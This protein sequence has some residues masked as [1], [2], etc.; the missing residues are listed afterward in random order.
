[1]DSPGK[2]S[3]DNELQLTRVLE[4]RLDKHRSSRDPSSRPSMSGSP[5]IIGASTVAL[6]A[7]TTPELHPISGCHLNCIPSPL[8]RSSSRSHHI[9]SHGILCRGAAHR[10]NTTCRVAR[11]MVH[12]NHNLS[13]STNKTYRISYLSRLIYVA[14]YHIASHRMS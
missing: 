1:M 13:W 3:S 14:S 8:Y 10:T 2:E 7:I 11:S 5:L 12:H 4:I 9:T 6:G